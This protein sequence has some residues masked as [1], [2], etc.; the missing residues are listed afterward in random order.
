MGSSLNETIQH[1][2]GVVTLPTTLPANPAKE[3][4]T[5]SAETK[6]STAKSS[7]VPVE[8]LQS[9]L[10]LKCDA[11]GSSATVSMLDGYANGLPRMRHFCAICDQ[12]NCEA[13]Q[14]A[15]QAPRMSETLGNLLIVG[16]AVLGFLA[17][18]A[19]TV[20]LR[21]TGGFGFWQQ[22]GSLIC[23][24]FVALGTVLRIGTLSI[25]GLLGLG[26]SLLA[27]VIGPVG[28]AG[29]GWKQEAAILFAAM[30]VVAGLYLQRR[31]R[32][33]RDRRESRSS[34]AAS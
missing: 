3:S 33:A 14:A 9:G 25:I 34:V 16:G 17:A 22:T 23:V 1:A 27:D 31:S 4:R 5:T 20:S 10:A 26:V 30:F 7:A 24:A 13:E 32:I 21:P 6:P 2:G 8:K 11:C 19:D 28:E 29:L 12:R 15:A 18:A